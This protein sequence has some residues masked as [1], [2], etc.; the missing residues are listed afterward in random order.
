M[1]QDL[2]L[3]RLVV[4]LLC[5]NNPPRSLLLFL[6]VH[7]QAPEPRDL[8][9][10]SQLLLGL[11]LES[12]VLLV[13]SCCLVQLVHLELLSL[14]FEDVAKAGSMTRTTLLH[15]KHSTSYELNP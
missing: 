4:L 15:N 14:V 1:R 11:L 13:M 7:R 10:Q 9:L 12:R 2:S 5:L 6:R 8:L 3:F